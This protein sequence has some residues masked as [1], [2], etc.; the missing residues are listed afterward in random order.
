MSTDFRYQKT[1]VS[2]QTCTI[3]LFEVDK[4]A[5]SYVGDCYKTILPVVCRE[6]R[7][8]I[9][10]WCLKLANLHHKF[11]F[12]KLTK[13]IRHLF[14]ELIKH[15]YLFSL[16]KKNVGWQTCT[17]IFFEVDKLAPAYVGDCYETILLVVCRETRN[18]ITC[19][20]LKFANLHH[21]FFFFWSWRKS[22]DICSWSW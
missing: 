10:W 12:S 9:T 14:M 17:I 16:S 2:W 13:V 21:K 4:L 18:G 5:P 8:C 7:N 19:W 20:C 3:I 1:N 15:V 22:S 6:T 11:F